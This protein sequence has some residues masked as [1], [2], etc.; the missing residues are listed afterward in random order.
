MEEGKT[1]AR[2]REYWANMCGNKKRQQGEQGSTPQV[3]REQEQG[4]KGTPT[5]EEPSNSDDDD[6]PARRGT[7]EHT[8]HKPPTTNGGGT[9]GPGV[10]ENK[11]KLRGE[12]NR[13]P[14]AGGAL[15]QSEVWKITTREHHRRQT[16]PTTN[17]NVR[18]NSM[19]GRL[20]RR[21]YPEANHDKW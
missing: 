18:I 3:E 12:Q 8:R 19:G 13:R 16:K 20:L 5:E 4:Q 1:I 6:T 15:Q 11:T 21:W 17:Y 7:R 2:N 10:G 9:R 14:K